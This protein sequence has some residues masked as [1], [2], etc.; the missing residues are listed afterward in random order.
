VLVRGGLHDLCLASEPS[1]LS[2]PIFTTQYEDF[3]M[4]TMLPTLINQED[5]ASSHPSRSSIAPTATAKV[6]VCLI[7]RIGW[8]HGQALKALTTREV[9]EWCAQKQGLIDALLQRDCTYEYQHNLVLLERY[10]MG[11][12]DGRV[13][14]Q[15]ARVRPLCGHK[16]IR[17]HEQF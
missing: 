7:A 17:D 13:L 3:I 9:E 12:E 1:A 14:I 15:A 2:E 5:A 16:Y 6:N 11:L 4:T 10:T 8:C